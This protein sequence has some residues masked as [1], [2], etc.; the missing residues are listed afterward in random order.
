MS[1]AGAELRQL[2]EDHREQAEEGH[3]RLRRDFR[4]LDDRLERLTHDHL[5]S[6][7]RIERIEQTPVNV[8]KVAWTTRQLLIIV[9]VA[10]SLGGGM[11]QLH[12][13]M[14]SQA[15]LQDE[16]NSVLEKQIAAALAESR[17]NG[18]KTDDLSKQLTTYLVQHT[19]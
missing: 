10:L 19:K 9:M 12:A 4:A 17:L 1:A 13:D 6:M 2:I 5:A 15:K 18:I 7:R 14:A 8:E 16:R 11:W 3:E